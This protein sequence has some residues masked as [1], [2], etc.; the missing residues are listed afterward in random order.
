MVLTVSS[1]AIFFVMFATHKI[2]HASMKFPQQQQQPLD[3]ATERSNAVP[4]GHLWE[5]EQQSV[6][7]DSAGSY[8]HPPSVKRKRPSL[9]QQRVTSLSSYHV[10][11]NHQ[12]PTVCVIKKRVDLHHNSSSDVRKRRRSRDHD[13]RGGRRRSRSNYENY[14][15]GSHVAVASD[16]AGLV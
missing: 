15:L 10:T 12:L 16:A 9:T 3:G 13:G 14:L 1:P 5:E 11:S 8:I 2:Y 7:C 4:E 6:V